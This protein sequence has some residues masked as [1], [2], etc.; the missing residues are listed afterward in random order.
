MARSIELHVFGDTL[1]E[2]DQTF[3]VV[4]SDPVNAGI[5]SGLGTVTILNDD[6]PMTGPPRGRPSRH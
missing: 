2:P 5:G 6:G 1:P 3:V 4:L